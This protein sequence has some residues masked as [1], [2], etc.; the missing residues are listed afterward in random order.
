MFDAGTFFWADLRKGL[1]VQSRI[2]GALVL[3][4]TR[5]RFGELQLGYAWALIEPLV[6][7]AILV[8]LFTLIGRHPPLGTSYET[9]FLNGYVP[10]AFYLQI[11]GRSAQAISS[12][13]ALLSFPPVR[14]MDTVWARII[15][16]TATGLTSLILLIIVF[17]YLGVPVMPADFLQYVLGFCSV[18]ALAAGI[19][20]F[21]AALSPIWSSWMVIYSWITKIQYFLC[22]IFFL[23]D[24]MPPFAREFLAY[25]PLAHSIIWIREGFYPGYQSIILEKYYPFAFAIIFGIS[26]L[27]LERLL[28]RK[29]DER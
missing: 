14:N 13:R 5:T 12:N 28:R 27:L 23:P 22:G 9:F 16:E 21:N 17:H 26:G 24:L 4:E 1:V 15:L 7:I 10:Y 6:Q 19:G 11:S 25:N 8:M 20:L 2:V 18:V 29:V 3:R